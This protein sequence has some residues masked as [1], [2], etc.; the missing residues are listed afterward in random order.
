MKIDARGIEAFLRNPGPARVVLLHGDDEGMVRHRAD[1]LTLAVIG[2]RDDPFRVAW[3][4]RDDHDRLPE[5]AT[6]I[7]MMPGR[8]VV[9]VREANE[10][11]GAAVQAVLDGAGDSLVV[12]EA[13]AL[14]ARSKLRAQVEGAAHAASIAC[15][16]EEAAALRT[17]VQQTLRDAGIAID[18]DALTWL[19]DHLGADRSATRN[20]L[21]KLVL[22][23]GPAGRV[24]LDDAQACVGDHS[25]LSLDDALFA[26]TSGDAAAADRSL[27]R[28][29]QEG[30][31]GVQICRVLL[32]HLT[33]LHAARAA[34]DGGASAEDAIRGLRPPVFFKRAPAFAATLRLWPISRLLAALDAVRRTEIACKQTGAAEHLLVSRLLLGIAHQAGHFRRRG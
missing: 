20:E 3:L 31:A 30:A 33:R 14:P 1:A 29:M 17:V 24:A 22:Y 16:P 8:R 25:L 13:G 5:E 34:M 7:A 4:T 11:L 28:A 32:G 26:A 6:A 21:E 10:A 2:Q 23:A 18:P 15:Y 12:L 19:L 9:R 27:E